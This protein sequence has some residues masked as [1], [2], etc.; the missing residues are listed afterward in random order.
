[1]TAALDAMVKAMGEEFERQRLSDGHWDINFDRRGGAHAGQFD[2]EKVARAG[3]AAINDPTKDQAIAGQDALDECVDRDW[4]SDADGNRY[5][6]TRISPSAP[7]S[8]YRAMV[9]KIL[10]EAPNPAASPAPG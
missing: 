3:L 8:V 4:D 6:Y 1:M 5:D 7:A 2:L 10:E 9:N